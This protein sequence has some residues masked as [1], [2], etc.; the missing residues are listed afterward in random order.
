MIPNSDDNPNNTR[1]VARTAIRRVGYSG[2]RNTLIP[3]SR[4]LVLRHHG[5][6]TGFGGS[7]SSVNRLGTAPSR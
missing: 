2:P 6:L 7:V 4:S 5:N 1:N 3:R